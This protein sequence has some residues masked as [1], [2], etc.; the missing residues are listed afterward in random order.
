LILSETDLSDIWNSVSI[1]RYAHLTQINRDDKV[2][3][4]KQILSFTEQG[5]VYTYERHSPAGAWKPVL[6]PPVKT[7]I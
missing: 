7:H 5:K 1:A 6:D 4:G 2:E 3:D